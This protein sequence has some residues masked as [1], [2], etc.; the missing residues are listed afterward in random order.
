MLGVHLRLTERKHT[1]EAK[2]KPTMTPKEKKAAKRSK[3]EGKRAT[4]AIEAALMSDDHEQVRRDWRIPD[5]RAM[6]TIFFVLRTG[7]QRR[8][9]AARPRGRVPRARKSAPAG[10]PMGR[11]AVCCN[12]LLAIA[13]IH[14][15]GQRLIVR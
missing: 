11:I 13:M 4:S 2:K 6:D 9:H 3:K 10:R 1:K 15:W 5:R 12:V 14:I 7:C 8:C